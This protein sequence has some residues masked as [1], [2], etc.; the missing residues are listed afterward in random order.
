MVTEREHRINRVEYNKR[1]MKLKKKI[2]INVKT[3][4]R[5]SIKMKNVNI[6]STTLVKFISKFKMKIYSAFKPL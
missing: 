1:L 4:L 3:Q 6:Y 5:K 2:I